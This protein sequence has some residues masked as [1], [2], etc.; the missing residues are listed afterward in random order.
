[1]CVPPV[2]QAPK[3]ALYHKENYSNAAIKVKKIGKT[4]KKAQEMSVKISKKKNIKNNFP[5]NHT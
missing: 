3:S 1:M 4:G 5:L 2:Y